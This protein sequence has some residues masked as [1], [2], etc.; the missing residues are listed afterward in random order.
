[1]G[2]GAEEAPTWVQY[3]ETKTGPVL[4]SVAKAFHI[5]ARATIFQYGLYILHLHTSI[6]HFLLCR[7]NLDTAIAHWSDIVNSG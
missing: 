2:Q 7:F 6:G 1:M 3:S 4:S 5:V